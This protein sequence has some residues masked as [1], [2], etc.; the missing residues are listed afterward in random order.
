M[1]ADNAVPKQRADSAAQSA[2]AVISLA[3]LGISDRPVLPVVIGSSKQRVA[4]FLAAHPKDKALASGLHVIAAGEAIARALDALPPAAQAG[5]P[6]L[7]IH[8]WSGPGE[9]EARLPRAPALTFLRSAAAS[10]DA[11]GAQ[12]SGAL[13]GLISAVQQ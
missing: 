3:Y 1:Q 12:P 2:D 8:I 7:S 6:L 11:A 4:A 9:E 5:E 10:L 13:N